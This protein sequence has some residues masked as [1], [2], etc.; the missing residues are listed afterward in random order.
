MARQS[1]QI[2]LSGGITAGHTSAYHEYCYRCHPH[3]ASCYS[4]RDYVNI[5][6]YSIKTKV[7][8]ILLLALPTIRSAARRAIFG[9]LE[10]G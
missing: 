4:F 1:T 2:C 6:H 8:L 9:G 10:K 3:F 5:E 7:H